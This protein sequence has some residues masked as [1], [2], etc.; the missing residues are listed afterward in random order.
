MMAPKSHADGVISSDKL[1]SSRR[2]QHLRFMKKLFSIGIALAVT[3]LALT[4]AL[5]DVDFNN[6]ARLLSGADY[7]LLLP[8][9]MLLAVFYWLKAVRWANILKP[10]GHFSTVQVT[11]ALFIGFGGNNVLPAHLGDLLRCFVFAKRFSKP[12]S[13]VLA[14]LVLERLLDLFV[15]L[16]LFAAVLPMLVDVHR[17]LEPVSYLIGAVIAIAIAAIYLLHR[18]QARAIA[19][20][21]RWLP[22]SL[23]GPAKALLENVVVALSGLHDVRHV[24][25]LL[26]NSFAQWCCIGGIVWV[27]LLAFDTVISPGVVV[28]VVVVTALAIA[29][30]SAPG[31]V[32]TMQAAFVLALKPFGVGD[33]VAFAASVFFLVAQWIPVTALGALFFFAG[34]HSI[35][36]TR[37]LVRNAS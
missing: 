21:H 12:L 1:Q 32:G 18:H 3:A 2:H 33:E 37:K 10:I 31:Y 9:L 36:E 7:A 17:V 34:G 15:V 16:V 23:A 22:K 25:A 11:P 26:L 8:F 13:G 24:I 20:P 14:S 27:S 6:L 35:A 4:Y 30:P 28:V 5:W 19:W 29:V